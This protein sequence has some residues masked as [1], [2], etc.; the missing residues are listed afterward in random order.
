MVDKG[1]CK[2]MDDSF[3]RSTLCREEKSIPKHSPAWSGGGREGGAK[4]DFETKEAM[5][6]DSLAN[7]LA[8]T[9]T[10]ELNYLVQEPEKD[11]VHTNKIFL[12]KQEKQRQFEMKRKLH[13]NQ[14]LNIKLARQL[15]SKDLQREDEEDENKESWHA[16][17]Q[18]KTTTM[19]E[20]EEGPTSDEELQT[21]SFYD[22]K[23]TFDQRCNC[24]SDPNPVTITH[25]FLFCRA[26]VSSTEIL[27]S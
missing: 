18:D 20:S 3:A 11:G 15:I 9:D 22:E 17:S 6:L 5:T 13:Y 24:L 8:T 25:G 2:P 19:E 7:K 12:D 4:S 10:S 16:T 27:I 23:T 21:Q 1:S 26:H 14:G